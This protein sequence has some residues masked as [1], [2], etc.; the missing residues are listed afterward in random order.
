MRCVAPRMR[1][2]AGRPPDGEKGLFAGYANR[3]CLN[4]NCV[5]NNAAFV[6]QDCDFTVSLFSCSSFLLCW[7]RMDL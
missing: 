3:K 4:V 6:K 7:G 5:N 2:T 1:K